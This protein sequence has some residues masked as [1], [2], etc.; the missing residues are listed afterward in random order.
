MTKNSTENKYAKISSIF[1]NELALN[2]F[3]LHHSQLFELIARFPQLGI[4]FDLYMVIEIDRNG[5]TGYQAFVEI[6]KYNIIL[7]FVFSPPFTRCGCKMMC[8][9]DER[10][11]ASKD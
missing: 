3:S 2:P 6:K 10:G 1:S 11:P 9:R 5:T 4:D 7:N 8:V